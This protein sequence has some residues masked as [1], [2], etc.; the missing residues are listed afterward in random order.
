MS[1]GSFQTFLPWQ[2]NSDTGKSPSHFVPVG[3]EVAAAE[4]KS[5]ASGTDDEILSESSAKPEVSAK[6]NFPACV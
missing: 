4:K 1:T 5:G 3:A 6:P 2:R